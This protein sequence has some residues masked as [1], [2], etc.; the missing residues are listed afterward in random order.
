MIKAPLPA[1]EKDRLA[2]L[3]K[4]KILDTESDSCFDDI[5]QIASE[6]CGTKISLISLVDA[7][8]QWF[9]S[10][11]GLDAKETPRYVSWCGHTILGDDIFEIPDSE[12]D[13]R[14][15]DN[16][17]HTGAPHV[18]FYAGAPLITSNGFKLGTLCVIDSEPKSLTEQ[19]KS[20]LRKLANQVM[21][22]IESRLR[23]ITLKENE[24]KVHAIFEGSHDAMI[25]FSPKEIIDC[26]P[27]AVKLYQYESKDIF[28]KLALCDLATEYQANGELSLK[29]TKREINIAFERGFNHFECVHIKST[30]E[31]FPCEILFSAFDYRGENVIIGT[32]RDVSERKGLEELSKD[33]QSMA[34]VGGWNFDTETLELK[35]TEETYRIHGMDSNQK[36]DIDFAINC[37]LSHDRPRIKYFVEH[38][39][40]NGVPWDEEFEIKD[41][42]GNLKWVR[43]IGEAVRNEQG[44]IFKLKG[45]FQDITERKKLLIS[46]DL[47]RKISQHQAKLASIG[48]LAA[49][50]G[51]EINNPLAI[52]KG[53]L[54]TIEEDLK[55]HKHQNEQTFYMLNKI[56]VASNRI[57]NIVSGLRTF[58][59]S[60]A[61]QLGV[62]SLKEAI[63][64]SF[65]LF[66]EIYQ[67]EG[68]SLKL[69]LQNEG[70]LKI[71]GN[72][73]RIGQV[74][75]NLLSNAK[76][77][78]KDQE[79]RTIEITLKEVS[80]NAIIKFKDNG[81]GIPNDIKEK[82]FDP[83][84]T[85]KDVNQGTGIGL[86]IVSSIIK[87]HDG[88]ITFESGQDTGTTFTISLPLDVSFN[89]QPIALSLPTATEQIK[90]SLKTLIVEDEF[91][92]R[93][94]LQTH[95]AKLGMK[96]TL[97][98]N[99]QEALNEIIKENYELIISDIKMPVMSGPV[100]VEKIRSDTGL[101]QPKVIIMSGGVDENVTDSLNLNGMVDGYL[102]KPFTQQKLYDLI[103]K[104]FPPKT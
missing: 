1:D 43:A 29:K 84:F 65:N 22:L 20:I 26:N 51:H 8:R 47:Q 17:L 104:I 66:N 62:F 73:G 18:R 78:T 69:D 74:I 23:E 97:V 67:K 38:G 44:K 88:E 11:V 9:K 93:M 45:T 81:K 75:V 35:W 34:K 3:Q 70:H 50:V 90:F 94:I 52:I 58:S 79:K 32:F 61:T 89:S 102:Y 86:S 4:Y 10:A 98:E 42:N 64:E 72:K 27:K 31:E 7:N 13:E 95:C 57:V 53:Y 41:L 30:G 80:G 24:E 25:I 101:N 99:G 71:Y 63:E 68:I 85:T 54:L 56:N 60:D 49:G 2:E 19:Q 48:Q 91:D 33:V 36:V 76:D 96:V 28:L 100:L 12:L 39:I 40:E 21:I 16:P 77:A 55:Q 83:F 82:V 6:I 14:F 15:K 5:T 87:E 59:R 37:Y 103:L 46:L 92:I